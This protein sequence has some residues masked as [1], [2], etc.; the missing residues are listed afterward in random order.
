[1][2]DFEHDLFTPEKQ[3]D[4]FTKYCLR[5]LMRSLKLWLI[6]RV[7][8]LFGVED[9]FS[10]TLHSHSVDVNENMDIVEALEDT[11]NETFG[12]RLTKKIWY[13]NLHQSLSLIHI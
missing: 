6:K 11:R 12:F 4:I 5:N 9:P 10:E 13:Q 8:R 7:V 2:R 1:M 3:M